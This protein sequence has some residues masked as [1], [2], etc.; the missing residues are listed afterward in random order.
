MAKNVFVR[1]RS[2]NDS[3][4]H[5]AVC[6][7]ETTKPHRHVRGPNQDR[8]SS[9]TAAAH[10]G[11][12]APFAPMPR[13]GARQRNRWH[14]PRPAGLL[15][16]STGD[17]T[18]VARTFQW[19]DGI[20]CETITAIGADASLRLRLSPA[21][22]KARPNARIIYSQRRDKICLVKYHHAI[23]GKPTD[24]LVSG[25]NLLRSPADARQTQVPRGSRT[26]DFPA[27]SASHG[28]S[29]VSPVVG[30]THT[31]CADSLASNARV[32]AS[33]ARLHKT[34]T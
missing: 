1:P 20:T 21:A 2:C 12:L 17:A 3:F 4:C 15:V 28:T 5:I 16:N 14:D 31:P 34:R 19:R 30:A 27:P 7:H 29:I 11:A 13:E 33:S 24:T 6:N 8:P 10:D 9:Q 18:R 25:S 22:A 32:A 26:H 23:H